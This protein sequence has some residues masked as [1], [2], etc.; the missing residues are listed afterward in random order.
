MIVVLA[1]AALLWVGKKTKVV[2]QASERPKIHVGGF[3]S[4]TAFV[5]DGDNITMGGE[6]FRLWGL[7]APEWNQT[8]RLPGG[9]IMWSGREAKAALEEMV[10]GKRVTVEIKDL[11]HY[12]RW[13]ARVYVGDLDINRL[14]VANGYAMAYRS[15][16]RIYVREEQ[17]AKRERLGMWRALDVPIKP[18]AFR[19]AGGHLV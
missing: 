11:D 17:S 7:D 15:F 2:A 16:T 5:T 4:G 3:Y 19:R 12:G 1:I 8:E 14:M 13:I 10:Q 9:K 6:S 18:W